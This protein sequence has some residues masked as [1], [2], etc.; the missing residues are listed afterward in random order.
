[1]FNLTYEHLVDRNINVRRLYSVFDTTAEKMKKVLHDNVNLN[2]VNSIDALESYRDGI[3]KAQEQ[4]TAIRDDRK[5]GEATLWKIFVNTDGIT[6]M[7][8]KIVMQDLSKK[9][10]VSSILLQSQELRNHVAKYQ[11]ILGG[12][13]VVTALNDAYEDRFRLELKPLRAADEAIDDLLISFEHELQKRF[14]RYGKYSYRDTLL[15]KENM[16]KSDD[17]A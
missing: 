13:D 4:V 7:D 11:S 8:A 10:D 12:H 6:L 15:I 1:M 14:K 9:K 3:A 2:S 16:V 5:L 17:V